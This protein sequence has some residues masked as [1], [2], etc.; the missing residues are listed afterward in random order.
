M[1]PLIS[2]E[3][4]SNIGSFSKNS[5][6]TLYQVCDTCTYVNISS[7]VYPN[8]TISNLNKAMT[9][10]DNNY[11]WTFF[12]ATQTGEYLYTVCGNKGGSINCEVI[13]FQVTSSGYKANSP[14][15]VLIIIATSFMLIIGIVLFIGFL[16]EKRFQFKWSMFL[17]AFMFLL[18]ALN[19]ISVVIS[20]A[21]INPKII[22]FFDTLT[23][24][25]LILFWF[26][27]GLL[28]IMWFLTMLQTY[29]F[30]K[31]SRDVAKFGGEAGG[32]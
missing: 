13:S 12:N 2:A 24:I 5:N 21:L 14:D 27:F 31:K 15:S 7:L 25:A 9:K 22:S 30:R 26:A 10:S 11:N 16:R 29:L 32:Y 20:D 6:I 28:A 1:F 3:T 19:L 18:G 8:G 17:L 4:P 23:A